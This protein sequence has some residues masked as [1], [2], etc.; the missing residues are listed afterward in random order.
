MRLITI[1]GPGGVGKTTTALAVGEALARTYD[2]VWFVDLSATEDPALVPSVFGTVLGISLPSKDPIS[3]LLSFLHVRHDLILLDNCEHV[4]ACVAELVE[5]IACG[6]SHVGILATSR[7]PLLAKGEYVC[8]LPPLTCPPES[9]VLTVKEA[10]AFPAVQLFVERAVSGMENFALTSGNAAAVVSLCRR[11][12][13]LPLAIELV[14]SRVSSFGVD[15]LAQAFGDDLLL[16][17]K[18][19]RTARLRH[20]SLRSTL[21][22]S[23]RI[24][25]TVEQ[26]TLRRLSVFRGW[27]SAESA[28]AVVSSGASSGSSLDA[29]MSLESKSLLAV[30]VTGAVIRYRLLHTTRAYAVT[31]LMDSGERDEILRRH[32]EH[33]RD[34][35]ESGLEHWEGMKRSEWVGQYGVLIDD[36]RA[37]QDWAFGA[38]NLELGAALTV[39]ALAFGFQ[40][41]LIDETI[42]RAKLAMAILQKL[43][44]PKLVWEMRINNILVSLLASIGAPP[45]QILTANSRALEIAEQLGDYRYRIEPLTSLTVTHLERG[46]YGASL[47]HL[48]SLQAAAR[49]ADDAMAILIADR[50]EAQARHYVGDHDRARLLAERVLRQSSGLSPMV[51]GPVQMD[52]QVSMRII[53]ARTLWLTGLADQAQKV[54]DEAVSRSIVD[55]SIAHCHTLA[56][57]ACPIAF[58]RGDTSAALEASRA[59]VAASRRF[60]LHKYL[61]L[62][63]CYER[64]LRILDAQRD[65]TSVANDEPIQDDLVVGLYRDNLLTTC[66]YWFDSMALERARQEL[67][68]WA[69]PEVLRR[70][71]MKSL[72]EEAADL[73]CIEASLSE[74]L[75]IARGQRALAWE[76]RTS[77]SLARVRHAQ[78]RT[79]HALAELKFVFDRF[80]EGHDTRDLVVAAMLLDSLGRKSTP[81]EVCRTGGAL[82]SVGRK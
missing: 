41:S 74:S 29:V 34:L 77:I 31:K 17:A 70:G 9:S 54:I 13:G 49:D 1:V 12:D 51:Y 28:L 20:Q 61:Q 40:L 59:L 60:S 14:A 22:W 79:S 48:E 65:Q 47:G 82:A 73:R 68:G 53:L 3:G 15:A 67:C 18:G 35:L 6:T 37:A 21:E 78:G 50:V 10:L 44:S 4:I 24:L 63:L 11:L 16:T 55:G 52:R 32:A 42:S 46:N 72:R 39:A 25:P 62:G 64:S 45:V 38:G 58:W 57:G 80:E 2:K 43:A 76:L 66:D 75:R 7:E 5:R 19:R 36:V 8:N 56:V 27:F 26:I 30:D 69:T 81:A 33:I 23:Y 71:A